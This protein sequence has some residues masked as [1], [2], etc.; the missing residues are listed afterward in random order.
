M[1]DTPSTNKRRHAGRVLLVGAATVSLLLG[2]T[3]AY[4]DEPGPQ[5]AGPE[6]P[7]QLSETLAAVHD[8]DGEPAD[9]GTLDDTT[10]TTLESNDDSQI[11]ITVGSSGRV[12][13][14]AAGSPGFGIDFADTTGKLA[15]A[16]SSGTLA[17]DA[18][19][20][21]TIVPQ[22]KDRHF[23]GLMVLDSKQ[24]PT[25]Y[26]IDLSGRAGA[27]PTLSEDGGVTI[28]SN[29][30]EPIGGM[31]APWAK[32][33]NNN[34]VPTHFVIDGASVRQVI[35]TSALDAT[36][37]PVVAD[38]ATYIDVTKRY[39]INSKNQGN[40]PKKWWL[41]NCTAE[42]GRTC[43]LTN[44]YSV[45]GSA[46][47]SLGMSA[48]AVSSSLGFT[49]GVS[50]SVSVTCGVGTSG[51]R[52]ATAWASGDKITYNVKSVRTYGVPPKTKQET[53]TSGTLTAYKPNGRFVCGS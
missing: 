6:G 22:L 24:A 5:P 11:E 42:K 45:S 48:G 34:P 13:F 36:D 50:Y 25:E 10:A 44:I 7:A 51:P 38:P 31:L 37:F 4:A 15:P 43:S 30:G 16:D 33:A 47:A 29:D 1:E 49:L 28:S 8:P 52:S 12:D 19:D 27:I 3:A 14:A 18:G 21:A 17:F 39:V 40:V 46:Q 35:D 9:A 23:R 53:K 32:D 41:N 20:E 2:S 26:T